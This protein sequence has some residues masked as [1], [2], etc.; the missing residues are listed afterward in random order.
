MINQV[1]LLVKYIN[2]RPIVTF[3]KTCISSITDEEYRKLRNMELV[4]LIRIWMD[5]N[6]RTIYS[7]TTDRGIL[8][9]DDLNE[10]KI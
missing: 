5:I 2:K 1:D 7:Q 10:E 3:N 4:D 8:F 9:I 6:N